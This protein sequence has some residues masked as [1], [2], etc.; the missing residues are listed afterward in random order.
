MNIIIRSTSFLL[1]GNPAWDKLSKNTKINF[2]AYN[3]LFSNTKKKIFDFEILLIFSRDILDQ[4]S[5]NQKSQE[6]KLSKII[7]GIESKA[8]LNK[9]TKYLIFFSSY[10]FNNLSE[11]IKLNLSNNFKK[12]I[13][14][15]MY[16]CV[17]K[18]E[19]I[20]YIDIDNF[21]SEIGFNTCFDSRNFYHLR[22]PLSL[23]GLEVF[24]NTIKNTIKNITSPKKKVLLLD[25][26]NTLWGGV[27]GEVGMSNLILGQDGEGQAF[28]DFQRAIKKIKNLGIILVLLSKNNENDVRNVLRNHQD[29]IIKESDIAAFKVNWKSKSHNISELSNEL[30]LNTDSFVFWDDNPIEREIVKKIH[31]KVDVI[32]PDKN[33]ENWPKQLLEY[34]NFYKNK[35][36]KE[37]K[38]KT[39][40]YQKRTRFL[41]EKNNSINEKNY[42]K[43]INLTPQ[44]INLNKSNY[45][46]AEQMCGKINQFNFTSKRYDVNQL[47]KLDYCKL[48]NLKDVYG[49]HGRV[50]LIGLK[51][52]KDFMFVDLFLLS[53]RILGRYLENWIYQEI[54]KI[55]KKLK[56]PKIIFEF[57]PTEKNVVAQNFIKNIKLKKISLNNLK[58]LES[59]NNFQIEKKSIYYE[60]NKSFKNQIIDI[61]DNR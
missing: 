49:D 59:L 2:S 29:M 47:K 6:S 4:L 36:T 9:K 60:T 33:I 44:I 43:S 5:I 1:E 17:K 13:S 24:I 37:D 20:Y 50:G 38:T 15:K 58:K 19:N 3:D 26:D 53:C 39:I 8:K 57:I 23:N 18:N 27:L 54:L 56:K 34:K 55:Q 31:K 35:I 46:R 61:Y 45:L 28:K 12:I 40:Q 21:F 11:N 10:Y 52:F 51:I 16:E 32:D 41:E 25:C 30:Y 48:I 7:K 22:C 42:L 14:D